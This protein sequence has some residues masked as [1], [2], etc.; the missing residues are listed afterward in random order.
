MFPFIDEKSNEQN[1]TP[2]YKTKYFF[3]FQNN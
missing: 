3:N 2:T 1:G